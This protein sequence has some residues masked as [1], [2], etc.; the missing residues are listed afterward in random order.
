[1]IAAAPTGPF[2]PSVRKQKLTIKLK[3]KVSWI[4]FGIEIW[5]NEL[6]F[7]FFKYFTFTVLPTT[8]DFYFKAN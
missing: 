5:P 8:Q 6:S 2:R 3:D 1:M 7:V 4:E